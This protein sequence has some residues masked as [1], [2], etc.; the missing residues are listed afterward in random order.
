MVSAG[1]SSFMGTSMPGL[2]APSGLHGG[3]THLRYV[4]PIVKE[5]L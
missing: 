2:G 4:Q 1:L 3:P 5:T